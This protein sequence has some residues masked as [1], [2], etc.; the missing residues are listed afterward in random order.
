MEN[1]FVECIQQDEI[2]DPIEILNFY[3]NLY[4]AEPSGTERAI[5]AS[6]INDLF[7]KVPIETAIK[8]MLWANEQPD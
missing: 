3:R 6:A 1:Y 7:K 4:Y 5:V 2:L 8:L